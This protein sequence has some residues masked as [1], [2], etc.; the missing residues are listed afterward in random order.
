VVC[1]TL[2]RRAIVKTNIHFAK[3]GRYPGSAN[4]SQ[5]LR[6]GRCGGEHRRRRTRRRGVR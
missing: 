2:L 3:S 6:G 4:S 1:R 5:G